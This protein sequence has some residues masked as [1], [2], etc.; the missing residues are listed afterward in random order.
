MRTVAGKDKELIIVGQVVYHDV[1]VCGHDLLLWCKLGTLLELKVANGSG[2]RQVAVHSS[3]IN[4]PTGRGDSC[5]FAYQPE[6]LATTRLDLD[7]VMVCE[8]P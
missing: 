2:K 7:L 6:S 8:W 1:W 5:L 4:K 3:E